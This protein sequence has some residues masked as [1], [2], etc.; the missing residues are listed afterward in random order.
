MVY[1]NNACRGSL[2][3]LIDTFLLLQWYGYN[4]HQPFR[5]QIYV[6]LTDQQIMLNS[7]ILYRNVT[8]QEN[9]P[10]LYP[11]KIHYS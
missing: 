11:P 9:E 3:I 5:Y 6:L 2:D 7:L 1:M 8:F 4:E 10:S